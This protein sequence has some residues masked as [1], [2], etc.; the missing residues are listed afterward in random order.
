[1][2]SGT[3]WHDRMWLGAIRDDPVSS[4][5][6]RCGFVRLVRRAPV[7]FC[8]SYHPVRC[9]FSIPYPPALCSMVVRCFTGLASVRL[10]NFVPAGLV[11]RNG[12]VSLRSRLASVQFFNA[13]SSGL[14]QHGSSVLSLFVLFRPNL[15][16]QATGPAQLF[17]SVPAGLVQCYSLLPLSLSCS[18]PAL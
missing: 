15:A 11:Q 9:D 6:A 10:F 4:G 3:E 12:S 14:V 1:M 13:V 17:N 16:I 2:W 7:Q 5:A 18:G 8:N